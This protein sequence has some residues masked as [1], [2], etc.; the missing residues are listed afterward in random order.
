MKIR[1]EGGDYTIVGTGLGFSGFSGLRVLELFVRFS[2]RDSGFGI[3][4]PVFGSGFGPHLLSKR[5]LFSCK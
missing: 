5:E 1:E 4:C 3:F 2:G